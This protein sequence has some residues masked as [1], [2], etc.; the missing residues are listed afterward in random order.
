M[1]FGSI[2]KSYLLLPITEKYVNFLSESICSVKQLRNSGWR[3]SVI[4]LIPYTTYTIW[5]PL[6]R[7]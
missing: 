3:T 7:R 6:K 4:Y 1:L 2:Q 5:E